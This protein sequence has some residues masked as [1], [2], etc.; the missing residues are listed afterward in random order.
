MTHADITT[1][2][3]RLPSGGR[4][5][6]DELLEAVYHE[7]RRIARGQLR[8]ERREHTLSATGLVH[9][10]W[11]RLVGHRARTFENRAHFFGAASQAMRRVLV[12]H[13]RG[14]AARKRDGERIALTSLDEAAGWAPPMHEV[15]AVHGALDDLAA[16]NERLVRVVECRYFA[17]LTIPETAEALGVSHTTVSEDWRF[18]RAWLHR[19]LCGAA[20]ERLEC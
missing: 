7:L 15:L 20:P 1:M 19:A 2:L 8:R 9:E 5:A 14:R 4:H 3:Y 13:A 17:G 16:L 6:F 11:L 18:A 12:D 10:A